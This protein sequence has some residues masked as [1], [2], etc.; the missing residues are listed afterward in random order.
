VGKVK[1]DL[2]LE[3]EFKET[4]KPGTAQLLGWSNSPPVVMFLGPGH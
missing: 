3:Q 4:Y 1:E 2:P